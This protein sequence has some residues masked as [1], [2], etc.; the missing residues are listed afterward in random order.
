[1]TKGFGGKERAKMEGKGRN[2][3]RWSGVGESVEDESKVE[4]NGC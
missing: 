2:R 1:M 4:R 3:R